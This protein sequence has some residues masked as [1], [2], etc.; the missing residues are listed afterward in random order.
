[1]PLPLQ[2]WLGGGKTMLIGNLIEQQFLRV[3]D[4]HFGCAISLIV[5]LIIFLSSFV[6]NLADNA[7][8]NNNNNN[9]NQGSSLF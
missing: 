6:L 9:N 3:G 2:E 1:M 5:I 7:R 4:W 8:N